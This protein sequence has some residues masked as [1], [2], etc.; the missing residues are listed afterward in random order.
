M[1]AYSRSSWDSRKGNLSD[2]SKVCPLKWTPQNP[3]GAVLL[4]SSEHGTWPC[5]ALSLRALSVGS[6]SDKRVWWGC[7]LKG[8][9]RPWRRTGLGIGFPEPT[10]TQQAPQSRSLLLGV[11]FVRA[12]E[13]QTLGLL[14]RQ[15]RGEEAPGPCFGLPWQQDLECQW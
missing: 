5:Y 10:W 15:V 4:N 7:Q 13:L 6:R 9:Q 2:F 11:G 8:P 14:Q 3:E 12:A 1:G